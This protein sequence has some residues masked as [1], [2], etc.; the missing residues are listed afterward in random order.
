VKEDPV[1]FLSGQIKIATKASDSY[2]ETIVR[3]RLRELLIT[4]VSLETGLEKDTTRRTL[5]DPEQS[6]ELLHDDEL[7]TILYGALPLARART[8]MIEKAADLIG[9]WK[10]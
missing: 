2:F 3:T 8:K 1:K 4:K 5:S 6:R 9:A 10:S 7:Y